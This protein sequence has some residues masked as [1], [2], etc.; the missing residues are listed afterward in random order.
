MTRDRHDHET[1]PAT[2]THATRRRARPVDPEVAD[3]TGRAPP[4]GRPDTQ[5]Y[6]KARPRAEPEQRRRRP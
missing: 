2:G 4:R 5:E 6:L 1:R 3:E